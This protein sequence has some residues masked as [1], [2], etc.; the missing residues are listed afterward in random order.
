MS[1][2]YLKIQQFG[3][4]IPGINVYKINPLCEMEINTKKLLKQFLK[5]GFSINP[6]LSR[7]DLW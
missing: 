5:E 1:R 3:N 6:R 7:R 2:H 4:I